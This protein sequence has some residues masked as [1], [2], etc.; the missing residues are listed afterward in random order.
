MK[1]AH[2]IFINKIILYKFLFH[3]YAHHTTRRF[4]FF[5]GTV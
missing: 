4:L 5:L 3:I 1:Q 2:K